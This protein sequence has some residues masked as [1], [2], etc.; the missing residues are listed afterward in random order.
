M[1]SSLLLA[2]LHSCPRSR[3]WPQARTSAAKRSWRFLIE[4]SGLLT[5]L[6]IDLSLLEHCTSVSSHCCGIAGS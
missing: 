1:S 3:G 6:P 5:W 2:H 4:S